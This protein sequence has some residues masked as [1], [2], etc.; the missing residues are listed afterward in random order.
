MAT[1]QGVKLISR[2]AGSAIT[3]YRLLTQ[4]ADGA[5]DM[6]ADATEK[7]L[8]V[9]AETVASGGT[10]PVAIPNGSV[11]K[12]EAGAA[13]AVGAECEAAGDATGRVITHTTGVG[14]YTVGTALTAAGAAG[15]VIS[16]QLLVDRDQA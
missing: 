10:V 4:A 7:P 13:I 14:D 16:V 3:V 15:D 5:V 12:L 1:S 8:G 6:V 11:V 9:S 2:V